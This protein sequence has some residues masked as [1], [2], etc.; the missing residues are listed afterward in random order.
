MQK[1]I[2]SLW[3]PKLASERSLRRAPVEGAFALVHHTQNTDRIYCLNAEAEKG[4]VHRGMNFSDARA[5]CPQLISRPADLLAD[6]RFMH[7][8][9]R[10]ARQFAP[11][12]GLE[13]R[14]G[15]LLDITGCAHLFGGEEKLLNRMQNRF[16]RNGLTVQIAIADTIGGAWALSHFAPKDTIAPIDKT[17]E[18]IKNLPIASLRLEEKEALSLKRLGINC[19]DQ[20]LHLP[21]KNVNRRFPPYVLEQLDK[22]MGWQAEQIT[23]VS[24]PPYFGVRMNLPD[25]I[26]LQSDVMA[27]LERLLNKLT[28]KLNQ[29]EYGA[30]HLVLRVRRVDQGYEHAELKL[31]RPMRD[32]ERL[33]RLFERAVGEI[34]AG[35][36]IDQM[37]LRAMGAEPLP[38]EQIGDQNVQ[39]ADALDDLISRIGSRIGIENI[40]RFL[41]R[42]THI[43][44]RCFSLAPAAWSK[45]V[46]NWPHT[47]PRPLQVFSP[48]P[49]EGRERTPPKSFKWRRMGFAIAKATGPERIAPEWWSHDDNWQRGLRDYWRV[50]TQQGQRLW[51][52]YTPQ[53]PAWFVQGTFA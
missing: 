4:G 38:T 21:R 27:G 47:P 46:S 33:L 45:P 1:R 34:D 20:L 32:P 10:W 8:L 24:D 11:W 17:Q 40:V 43:P 50:E 23:P 15:L 6:E 36:G 19:V 22:A 53:N 35:F 5:F 2:V 37:Q 49:I 48:E 28:A 14:D 52:F 51:L 25:P 7:G 12:V 42:A 18:A 26:G 13:G 3:F 9:A 44:E 39:N 31:A 41:P 30:N 16:R 29:Y